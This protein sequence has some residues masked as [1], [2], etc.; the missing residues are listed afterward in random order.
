M[1]CQ[2][3]IEV[4][5]EQILTIDREF[6]TCYDLMCLFLRSASHGEGNGRYETQKLCWDTQ[7][8]LI[9]PDT[10]Y[11]NEIS[12]SHHWIRLLRHDS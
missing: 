3:S 11:R 7:Y 2:D 1:I 5:E 10:L 4:K 9:V 8:G 6:K 12:H